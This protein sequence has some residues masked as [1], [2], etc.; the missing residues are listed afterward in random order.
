MMRAWGLRTAMVLVLALAGCAAPPP[1]APVTPAPATPVPRAPVVSYEPAAWSALPG[2]RTDEL[3]AAWPA[4]L[5]SCKALRSRPQ[6][7]A[8]CAQALAVPAGPRAIREYFERHFQ[9]WRIVRNDAAGRADQGLI[10]GYFE[11]LLKGSRHPSAR[12]T[13]PLY[14]PPP[15]LLTVDLSSLYPELAGKR[16]RGRLQGSTVVPYYTRAQLAQDPA[17]KGREIIW[18]DNALDAF[19]LEVQGSG[20]VQLPDGSMIRVEYADQNGHPY[21]SIGRY[22]VSRGALTVQQA[23]MPG[24]RAWLEA[25]PE[26][27]EEVLDANPSVVFFKEAPLGDPGVGPRGAQGVALTAGRSIAVD[28]VY[29][30]LGTPVFL[31]TMLPPGAGGKP[32]Q[33]LVMAQDTGGAIAG[34]PRADFFFGTGAGAARLAGQMR[35]QGALWVL[36]P[37]DAPL[38][39][40]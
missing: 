20:K 36:W 7:S 39:R 14:S 19:M 2:W 13:A 26:R 11:P 37:K 30:P 28:P 18:I 5:A 6:W 29:V 33:R 10:T 17:L 32:L 27:L 23:T 8:P 4:F 35:E 34:A 3:A 21:H 12:Y 31:S 25:H 22:L 1:P 15:D 24:I 40:Q 38:P 16:V 9:P